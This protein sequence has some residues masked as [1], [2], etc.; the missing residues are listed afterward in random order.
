MEIGDALR[1]LRGIPAREGTTRLTQPGE[2]PHKA[3]ASLDLPT[4]STA[5]VALHKVQ[6]LYKHYSTC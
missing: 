1:S 4:F 2:S 6:L 5:Q 3:T